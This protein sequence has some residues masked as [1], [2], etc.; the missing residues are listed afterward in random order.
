MRD[1]PIKSEMLV[2][3]VIMV[4]EMTI[5]CHSV[6]D[7]GTHIKVQRERRTTPC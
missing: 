3:M 6:V 7:T 5:I 2:L 1:R 4:I